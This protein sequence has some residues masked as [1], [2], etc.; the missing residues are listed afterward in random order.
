MDLAHSMAKKDAFHPCMANDRY[1]STNRAQI[2]TKAWKDI[3]GKVHFFRRA[4]AENI[5]TCSSG[6]GP[7]FPSGKT[8]FAL[9]F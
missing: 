2:L 3:P 7:V 8:H 5:Q 1:V 4:I 9:T 6:P